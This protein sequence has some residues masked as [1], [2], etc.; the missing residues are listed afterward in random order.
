MQD[1]YERIADES[2]VPVLLYNAPIFTGGV[3]VPLKTVKNLAS[4]PNIVGIKDSSPSGPMKFLSVIDEEEDFHILAGSANFF[5]PSLHLGA[6]GGILSLS[7]CIPEP[8]CELYRLFIEGRYDE[9]R[10][11]HF[12]LVR[13][14]AAVS[15]ASGVAGVKAA[16]EITGFRGGDPRHPLTPLTEEARENV[17]KKIREED[18][19]LE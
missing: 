13:L 15:S 12:R 14:N 17:R 7:N 9:A 8:C 11:L 16:M 4:H 5:Y 10:A 2:K 18:F 3:Q 6:S 1:Y 19:L